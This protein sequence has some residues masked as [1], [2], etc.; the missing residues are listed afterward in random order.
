MESANK[1]D[2]HF[3]IIKHPPHIDVSTF[4]I[5]YQL[6]SS[7]YH[8]FLPKSIALMIKNVV[9]VINIS[10]AQDNVDEIIKKLAHDLHGRNIVSEVIWL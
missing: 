6:A 7:C 8:I 9:I 3:L 5:K 1:I 10:Q 2:I 4:C